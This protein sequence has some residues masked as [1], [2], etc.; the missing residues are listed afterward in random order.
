MIRVVRNPVRC[1]GRGWGREASKV[2]KEGGGVGD[3]GRR[4]RG[5]EF[6]RMKDGPGWVHGAGGRRGGGEGGREK[7]GTGRG[8]GRVIRA[9]GRGRGGD[10]RVGEVDGRDGEEGE[11]GKKD[12]LGGDIPNCPKL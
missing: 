5:L 2:E 4:T 10:G 8:V 7:A 6:G 12:W 11:G 9:R 3:G 1:S